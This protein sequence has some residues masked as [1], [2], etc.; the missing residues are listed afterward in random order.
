MNLLLQN[1]NSNTD[2]ISH[3]GGLKVNKNQYEK[4]YFWFVFIAFFKLISFPFL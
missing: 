1:W 4:N 3:S 2:K